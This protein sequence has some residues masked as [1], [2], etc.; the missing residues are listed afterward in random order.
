MRAVLDQ[1]SLDLVYPQ[2]SLMEDILGLV[3]FVLLALLA[4]V[5]GVL[6]EPQAWYATLVKPE[7]A[8]PSWVFAPVWTV[9]YFTI[10]LSAWGVWHRHGWS[11]AHG[12]WFLQLIF[13][14]AWSPV[15]FGLREAGWAFGIIILLW[16]AIL[17]TCFA[18]GRLSLWAGLVL[19]PYLGWVGYAAA[20]NFMLWRLN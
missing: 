1:R 7:W 5:P 19:V 9:L 11:G 10:G 2:R 8:P 13:N 15:F 16:L 17:G 4:A 12:L 14:A 20:L 3:G 6:C 18:L